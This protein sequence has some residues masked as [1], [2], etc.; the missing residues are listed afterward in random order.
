[1]DAKVEKFLEDCFPRHPHRK[2]YLPAIEA[3][4]TKPIQ[5]SNVPNYT[6]LLGK[7]SGYP[8]MPNDDVEYL[9][10]SIVPVL[11]GK[12]GNSDQELKEGYARWTQITERALTSL[13]PEETFPLI[14]LWRVGLLDP[15]VTT[16]ISIA[17]SPSQS[18]S[19]DPLSPIL[20]LAAS[21]LKA[22]SSSTP[23]PFL[24]TVLRLL[25]NLLAP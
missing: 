14:D 1:L 5:S 3:I 2:L 21:T 4:P 22:S 24:L 13:Q 25:N 18:D 15:K 11:E 17:L 19:P 10:T 9:R 12:I 6:A 23:K 20:N 16:L 8:S 7:V